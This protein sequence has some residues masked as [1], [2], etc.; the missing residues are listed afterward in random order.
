MRPLP[1]RESTRTNHEDL[2]PS[3]IGEPNGAKTQLVD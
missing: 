2:P 1:L 3:T